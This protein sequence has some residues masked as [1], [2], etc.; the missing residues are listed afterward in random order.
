M[1]AVLF[2]GTGNWDTVLIQSIAPD[3]L[4]V[5]DRPGGRALT[6]SAGAEVAQIVETTLYFDAAGLTLRREHAGVSDFPQLDNV[7]DLR[8]DYFGDPRPPVSPRPPPGVAN[9]LY[10]TAGTPIPLPVLAADHG[11][12]ARLPVAMLSDGPMCGSGATAYDV[13]LLRIRMIRAWIRLQTGVSTLRGV[14]PGVFFRPGTARL[15][16]RT[17]PD[18]TLA[19]EITPPNIQR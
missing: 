9:C 11:A 4:V 5:V 12:L 19:I 1:D 17:L 15:V 6:Y 8:F 2:D 3:A 7:V 18:V 16:E 10:D 14:D 13:D